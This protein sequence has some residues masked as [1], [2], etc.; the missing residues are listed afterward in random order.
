MPESYCVI[1]STAGSRGEAQRL[2]DILVS[3]R[4]AACVQVVDISSTYVWDGQ[5]NQE[6][7]CLLLIKTASHL[8]SDVEAA[9]LGNHSYEVPEIL[10]L[11]VARGLRSYLDWVSGQTR[12]EA[13]T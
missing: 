9:I 13:G 10:E 2:A 12:P 11:P 8:Y 6:A 3:N 1:L 4:L 7:E 5:L